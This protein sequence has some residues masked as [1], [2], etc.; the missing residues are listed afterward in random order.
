MTRFA[1]L[2]T[3]T[4]MM[5]ALGCASHTVPPA[6]FADTQAAISAADA[7]GAQNEPQAALHL[8]MARDELAKAKA[9]AADDSEDEAE[10]ALSRASVDAEA[11]LMITREAAARREAAKAAQEVQSLTN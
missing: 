6:R 2:A 9:F 7:V 3:L 5:V 11:A 10:L 8:K 4:S 1:T